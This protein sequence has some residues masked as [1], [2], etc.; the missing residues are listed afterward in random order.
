MQR[1]VYLVLIVLLAC[2]FFLSSMVM[3]QPAGQKVFKWRFQ[4]HW[5]AASASFKPLKD[6]F[7]QKL[8]KLTDGRLQIIL[9]QAAALVPTKEIFDSCR[10]GTIEGATAS[11]A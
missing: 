11:P 7:E 1:K 3:A 8:T 5:P 2:F 10:K 9:F 6:F 4:S